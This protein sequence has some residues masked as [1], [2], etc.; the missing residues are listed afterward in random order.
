MELCCQ[1]QFAPGRV[2]VDK[3]DQGGVSDKKLAI[4]VMKNK[5]RSPVYPAQD[6]VNVLPRW[7]QNR[8]RVFATCIT[9]FFPVVESVASMHL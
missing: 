8:G 3:L 1:E 5:I 9:V 6:R 7:C 4:P 2:S